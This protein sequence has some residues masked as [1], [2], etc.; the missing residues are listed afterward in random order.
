[1][2][3]T[4]FCQSETEKSKI[5]VGFNYETNLGFRQLN[6][7]GINEFIGA[8]RN[9]EEVQKIGFTTGLNFRYQI[10]PALSADIGMLFARSGMKTNIASISNT[11]QPNVPN[12]GQ[13]IYDYNSMIIPI[14]INYA[15]KTAEKWN[16]YATTGASFNFFTSRNTTFKVYVDDVFHSENTNI[17]KDG[18]RGT[19]YS[20]LLGVGMNYKLSDSFTINL[21]PIYRQYI[22]SIRLQPSGKEYFYSTGINAVVFYNF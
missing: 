18:F 13:A 21:E 20:V 19:T 14:K 8:V 6:Y 5:S 4:A 17:Q 3:F 16:L 22:T 7:T 2:P 15:F 11:G 10:T 9:D 12:Q 1:M